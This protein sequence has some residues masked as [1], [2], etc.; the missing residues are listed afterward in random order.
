M[1][2]LPKS[3]VLQYLTDDMD[4][5]PALQC[6]NIFILPGVPA[7]FE[8]KINQL[9]ASSKLAQPTSIGESQDDDIGLSV[10][11]A[12]QT[13]KEQSTPPPRSDTYRI[14][15]ALEEESI[16]S[17]LNAS[18]ANHPHVSFGSYPIVDDPQYKTIVTL[19]GRFYTGGYTKGSQRLLEKSIADKLGGESSNNNSEEKR[20]IPSLFF[21]K[22]EMDRNV[23]LALEDL[24]S[25]LP[26]EGILCIDS[27][28][29]LRIK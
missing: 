4:E 24:K 11:Q 1:A 15:L 27:C 25:R 21:S 19:E 17:A 10:D 16:V 20:Q 12:A 14:V 23:E 26:E 5:W 9:A 29:D 7:Y 13:E 3:S 28:D 8:K 6:R 2:T 18:V 22:E